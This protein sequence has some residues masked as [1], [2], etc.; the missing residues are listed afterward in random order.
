M[1]LV[2]L[3][4]SK[5]VCK[6]D[7]V[8]ATPMGVVVLNQVIDLSRVNCDRGVESPT[9]RGAHLSSAVRNCLNGV[10]GCQLPRRQ[11]LGGWLL[12]VKL[13]SCSDRSLNGVF[14]VR[15]F[16]QCK[17]VNLNVFIPAS[18]LPHNGH[19]RGVNGCHVVPVSGPEIGGLI[20]R[21]IF[22]V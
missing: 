14:Q 15:Q 11:T 4:L 20:V 6:F 8:I 9:K 13:N 7:P 12:A 3:L 16:Q 2:L 17:D 5:S 1:P 18:E 22:V 10:G 21:D 19:D